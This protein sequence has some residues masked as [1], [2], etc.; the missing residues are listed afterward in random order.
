MRKALIPKALR[1]QVWLKGIG[2]H[3][4]GK[5][6]TTWCNN[7]INVFDFQVG[8]RVPESKGGTTTI[9]NLTP[10]C[11]RCNLSMGSQYTTDEWNSTFAS[12]KR[13][14]IQFCCACFFKPSSRTN[15]NTQGKQEVKGNT[16]GGKAGAQPLEQARHEG[17]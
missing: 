3:Y 10:L 6:T 7:I 14:W 2:K 15:G 5:C 4:E 8:H 16:E 17:V 13:T 1:E 12:E 11:S 9:D